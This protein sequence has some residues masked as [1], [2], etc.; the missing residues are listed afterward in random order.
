MGTYEK[1][2]SDLKEAMLAK[3]AD[4]VLVLRSLKAALLEREIKERVGG[5]AKLSEEQVEQVLRK[6]AK[7]RRDSIDQ[8]EQAGRTDLVDSEKK[9]L[10]IIESYL[11][12]MMSEEDISVLTDE[13]IKS[14]GA[15]SP[16]D[17]GK[18]MG[19]IMAKVRGKADG[20]VVSRIVKER[21]NA[22]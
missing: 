15:S 14:T 2:L 13:A 6:A 1:L 4:R 5:R 10:E 16:G 19:I 3:D 9:E 17:M 7:Q 21:L 20:A 18:V 12:E 22:L 11:P 8:F